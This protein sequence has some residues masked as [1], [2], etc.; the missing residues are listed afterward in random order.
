M[1]K[2]GEKMIFKKA[3]QSHIKGIIEINKSLLR[4]NLEEYDNGFLLGER[5]EEFILNKIDYYYVALDELGN[6]LGY[7]EIDD[8]ISY[9]NFALGDWEDEKLRDI[10]LEHIEKNKFVYVIQIAS[11]TQRKGIGSFIL[12]KLALEFEGLIIKNVCSSI[13]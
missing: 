13:S 5:S 10:L 11:K 2:C 12:E 4:K 1:G 8:K 6:V 3:E 9:D 7:V